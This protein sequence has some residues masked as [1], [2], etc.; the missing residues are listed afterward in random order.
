MELRLQN[1]ADIPMGYMSVT[2]LWKVSN[3][4]SIIR[5]PINREVLQEEQGHGATFEDNYKNWWHVSTI[6]I[7]TKNN[8]ERRLGIWP[9]GFDK[10]D[11]MYCNTAY[12]DYPTYLPQYAQGKDFTKGL[13][14]GWMLLNYNKPVQVS[15][16]LGGYQPNYAVDE[17]IKTYWSAKPEIPGNGSRQIWA[18]CLPSMPFRLIM[19]TRMLS[20]WGKP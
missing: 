16:T 10:D 7:S 3:T 13:F 1:S 2:N 9:A 19:Q 17:D 6:F 20:L 14:A 12:G 8:F 15:S 4:S 18:R 5:F 11:V